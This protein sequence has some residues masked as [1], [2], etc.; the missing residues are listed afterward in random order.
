M[1]GCK[2]MQITPRE[3]LHRNPFYF[4]LHEHKLFARGRERGARR[5]TC[6]EN[7]P[8]EERTEGRGRREESKRRREGGGNVWLRERQRDERGEKSR[9][10]KGKG[11]KARGKWRKSERKVEIKGEERK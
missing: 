6:G 9:G 4:L 8:G 7:D 5:G 11:V 1:P 10:E 3:T 2:I